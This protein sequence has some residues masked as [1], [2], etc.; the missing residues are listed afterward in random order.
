L[1]ALE[2]VGVGDWPADRPGWRNGVDDTVTRRRLGVWRTTFAKRRKVREERKEIMRGG[3]AP[4]GSF[5]LDI[6]S[7]G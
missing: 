7:K 6:Q 5:E 2:D 4:E 3:W 1:P